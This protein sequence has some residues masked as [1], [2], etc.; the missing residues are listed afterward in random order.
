MAVDNQV[1]IVTG[2]SR[3]IGK[4]IVQRL[5]RDGFAVLF[6]HSESPE[7]ARELELCAGSGESQI[8]ALQCDVTHD[9]AAS[10]IFNA[11]ERLGD[12]VG[13]VN[14]AGVTGPLGPLASLTDKD[15]ARV[16]DVN[17]TAP[18]RLCREASRRWCRS[19]RPDILRRIVNVSSVAARTGSP[20][21]Y[22]WYAATKGAV[23]SLT[24]GLGKELAPHGIL[25]NAVSPGTI[26]TSIHAR[27]GEPGRAA[28][29][30]TRIPLGRPGQAHEVANA[31]AWLFSG[32]C[33][34]VTATVVNVAGGL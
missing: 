34:Y 8:K 22:V 27:A 1:V 19:P 10:Q 18:I 28:R 26:E 9:E 24:I 29:V 16:M 13:L 21:E 11:A 23:E 17:L 32:E 4:S 5:H 30:A 14:N 31:V 33:S 6:T 7:E 25:V 15:L 2:G 20:G 12:V 3:G